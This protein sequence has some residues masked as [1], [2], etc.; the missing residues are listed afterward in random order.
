MKKFI[1]STVVLAVLAGG[2]IFGYM[3]YQKSQNQEREFNPEW[4]KVLIKIGPFEDSVEFMNDSKSLTSEFDIEDLVFDVCLEARG[5]CNNPDTFEPMS[6]RIRKKGGDTL[7]LA[8][9]FSASNAYGVSSEGTVVSY[10]I[11]DSLVN[12]IVF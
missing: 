6:C 11:N 12:T 4:G 2:G 10:H 8:L 1:I 9:K 5:L 3:M 7:E